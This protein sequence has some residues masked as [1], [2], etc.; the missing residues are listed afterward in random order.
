MV[1]FHWYHCPIK[2]LIQLIQVLTLMYYV[3][4]RT[5]TC[6]DVI[7]VNP[8]TKVAVVRYN[9]GREY[10]YKNVS[11]R[12]IIKLMADRSVSLGFFANQLKKLS[13]DKTKKTYSLGQ[14]GFGY[15]RNLV[16]ALPAL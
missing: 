11:R 15:E 2:D 9:N 13:K 10:T 7:A 1:Q 12:S 8:L 16:A 6:C 14:T 4:D 5:S 3:N